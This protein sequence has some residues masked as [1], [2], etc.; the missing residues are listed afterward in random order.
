MSALHVVQIGFLADRQ[1]RAPEQLLRDWYTLEYVAEAALAGGNRV[2]VLQACFHREHIRQRG[3]DYEFVPPDGAHAFGA[4]EFAARFAALEPDVVHVH[5]L[6]FHN[7]VLALHARRP[8]VPILLQDHADRP[9]RI[10]R[11]GLWRRGFSA[12][13]GIAFCSYEQ[14]RPFAAARLL[15]G[16]LEVFEIAQW[17]APFQPGDQSE[18]RAATGL[19]GDPCLLWVGHLNSNKDPLTV[20]DGLSLAAR[21]LPGF[22]MWC[23]FGNA[24]LLPQVQARIEGDSA[25]RGRVHLLG[26]VPHERMESLLRAADVFVLG[27]HREGSGCALIEAMGCGLTPVVSDIPSFRSLTGGGAVGRLWKAGDPAQFANA[28]LSIAKEPRAALRVATRAHFD[29]TASPQALGRQFDSI[30]RRLRG[31]SP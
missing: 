13:R 11:R 10:W 16:N 17:S 5:G 2:T 24:P 18:S 3:V 4:G 27:S 28:L 12:V 14:S 1:R 25:L 31:A 15:P 6:G 7:D 21:E 9:P 26:K 19:H 20:L 22:T 29:V 30:Y 8:A 23:C